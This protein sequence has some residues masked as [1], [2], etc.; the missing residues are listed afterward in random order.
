MTIRMVSGSMVDLAVISGNW[1]SYR[2]NQEYVAVAIIDAGMD[3]NGS[4]WL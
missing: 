2:E 3:T 1:R 4:I